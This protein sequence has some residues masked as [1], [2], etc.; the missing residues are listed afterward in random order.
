MEIAV[1]TDDGKSISQHF[2]RSSYYRVVTIENDSFVKRYLRCGWAA[3]I[4][5]TWINE[6]L[7]PTLPMIDTLIMHCWPTLIVQSITGLE[8][9]N[10]W[11]S[12]LIPLAWSTLHSP[13]LMTLRSNRPAPKPQDRSSS[14]QNM[15]LDFKTWMKYRISSWSIFFTNRVGTT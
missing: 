3:A 14:T 4:S 7:I 11:A 1:I 9:Y 12:L 15:L 5:Y 8:N 10:I 13:I 6:A 2:R